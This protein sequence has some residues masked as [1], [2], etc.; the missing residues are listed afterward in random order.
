M[1]WQGLLNHTR[2][3]EQKKKMKDLFNTITDIALWLLLFGMA[4]YAVLCFAVYY[5]A[6]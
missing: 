5:M 2:K 1:Y 3:Q 6:L 4:I